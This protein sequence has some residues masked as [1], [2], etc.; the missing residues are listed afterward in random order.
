LTQYS[1]DGL[2]RL[3]RVEVGGSPRTDLAYDA[4]DTRRERSLGGTVQATY[5]GDWVERRNGD[6]RRLVQG[7]GIDQTLAEISGSQVYP[8]EQDGLANVVRVDDGLT[9][10]VYAPRNGSF[11]GSSSNGVPSDWLVD[12]IATQIGTWTYDTSVG[13]ASGHASM[14]LDIPAAN[15]ATSSLYLRQNAVEAPPSAA[16]KL[17]I[18]ACFKT[19]NQQGAQKTQVTMVAVRPDGSQIGTVVP[20]VVSDAGTQAW[21]CKL[22]PDVLDVSAEP[23]V[24]VK[25]YSRMQSGGSGRTWVDNIRVVPLDASNHELLDPNQ[26]VGLPTANA[27]RRYEAFGGVRSTPSYYPV[28]RGFAGRPSEGTT[29]L[30]NLRARHYDPATGRFLRADPIGFNASQLYAYAANNPFV[31]W[32]PSG[33]TVNS[34][35]SALSFSGKSAAGDLRDDARSAISYEGA[36]FEETGAT[37]LW[38][39]DQVSQLRNNQIE[40]RTAL[41][42]LTRSA[43]PAESAYLTERLAPW[44]E[45]VEKANR[46]ML[47]RN[48][49]TLEN[50]MGFQHES[51]A[52]TS[53]AQSAQY[54]GRL[55]LVGGAALSAYNIANA[56]QGQHLRVAA[57]EAGGWASAWAIGALGAEAGGTLGLACGLAAPVCSPVAAV[58]GGLAGAVYG[59]S[60]G[61]RGAMWSYDLFVP[62]SRFTMAR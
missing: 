2:G 50:P 28:E 31:N 48:A 58:A 45:E 12:P 14:R 24:Q 35:S 30:I 62:P 57:G 27:S 59:G 8:L 6:K 37:R 13:Y 52:F 56:P 44:S 33:L 17:T 25:V 60:V 3:T 10:P 29:G 36:M 11:E 40:A 15:S 34:L 41:K 53:A 7:G 49:G 39:A 26:D 21:K 4:L 42:E 47:S 20:T 19:E 55:L 18:S 9:P 1:Y 61:Q 43:L 16:H 54:V 22:S 38:Y 32:D 5:F 51:A 46:L 23:S